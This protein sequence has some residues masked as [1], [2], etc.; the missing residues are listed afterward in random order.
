M[1]I[2]IFY[3]LVLGAVLP[4]STWAWYQATPTTTCTT[5][6]NAY[7]LVHRQATPQTEQGFLRAFPATY[8][9]FTAVFGYRGRDTRTTSIQF[10]CL[11][12]TSMPYIEQLF[13]LRQVPRNEIFVKVV[14]IGRH[15]YWQSDGLNYLQQHCIDLATTDAVFL[16]FLNKQPEVDIRSFTRFL[17]LNPVSN[18]PLKKQLKRAY[19]KYSHLQKVIR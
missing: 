3:L 14:G 6:R 9:A 18:E 12:A 16:T 17:L 19:A 2:A 4:H 7:A 15:A 1:K 5:V 8:S 10:G 11:Y 13:A